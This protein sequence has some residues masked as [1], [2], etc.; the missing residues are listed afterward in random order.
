MNKRQRKKKYGEPLRFGLT[1][2]QIRKMSRKEQEEW[3]KKWIPLRRAIYPDFI[4]K[5][6]F[7]VEEKKNEQI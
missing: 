4:S 5:E 3:I 1:R 2:R 6:I 7:M